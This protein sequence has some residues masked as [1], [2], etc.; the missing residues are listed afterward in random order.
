MQRCRFPVYC[1]SAYT[2]GSWNIQVNELPVLSDN[3]LL[4]KF[5]FMQILSVLLL[6]IVRAAVV[7]RCR[8]HCRRRRRRHRH[9]QWMA[10]PNVHLMV[11]MCLRAHA[12]SRIDIHLRTQRIF[13]PS[14]WFFFTQWWLIK[15]RKKNP[16]QTECD[17][18]FFHNARSG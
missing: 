9:T 3:K 14:N 5:V 1:S 17:N 4:H 6:K 13:K 16:N 11:W 8:C 2:N 15:R 18:Q 12:F 10:V 7:V